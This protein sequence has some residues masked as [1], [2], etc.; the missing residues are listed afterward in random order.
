MY[1]KNNT[2]QDLVCLN[3]PASKP[4]VRYCRNDLNILSCVVKADICVS[5]RVPVSHRFPLSRHA[6]PFS[7]FKQA[8]KR[9]VTLLQITK[10][11]TQYSVLGQGRDKNNGNTCQIRSI[12]HVRGS[13]VCSN[14][15]EAIPLLN[16]SRIL[17][18]EPLAMDSAEDSDSTWSHSVFTCETVLL[19]PRAVKLPAKL[20]TTSVKVCWAACV[21]CE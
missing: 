3:R 20:E 15:S 1:S 19:H 4:A 21:H 6:P 8:T 7:D 18:A 13:A 17:S 9:T 12:P 2:L 11:K 5:L 10:N 14:C 16:D